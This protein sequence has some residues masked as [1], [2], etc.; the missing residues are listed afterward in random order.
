[1]ERWRAESLRATAFPSTVDLGLPE[2]CWP[3]IAADKTNDSFVNRGSGMAHAVGPFLDEQLTLSVNVALRRAD[4]L[5]APKATELSA[6]PK[7]SLG[8]VR[9]FAQPFVDAATRFF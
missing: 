2:K 6:A 7:M 5:L 8:P 4:M 3:L 9:T 1:M